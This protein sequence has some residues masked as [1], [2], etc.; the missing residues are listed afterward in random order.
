MVKWPTTDQRLPL[1]K[2]T[3]YLPLLW[4]RCASTSRPGATGSF[5][6][7]IQ[8]RTSSTLH[9]VRRITIWRISFV[10]PKL[11]VKMYSKQIRH[12]SKIHSLELLS[13]SLALT[14]ICRFGS[15]MHHWHNHK[16]PLTSF[17]HVRCWHSGN[18]SHS[19]R[20]VPIG[21]GKYLQLVTFDLIATLSWNQI[22]FCLQGGVLN[23]RE[24]RS[25]F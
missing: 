7:H 9:T 15:R 25:K 2:M 23:G 24:G 20:W 12:F 16:W 22:Q 19:E 13:Y 1:V 14:G 21:P 4:D 18:C 17:C 5:G 6:G 10:T 3:F 8:G 11:I